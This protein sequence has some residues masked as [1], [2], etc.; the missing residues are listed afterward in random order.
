MPQLKNVLKHVTIETASRRRRC[1]RNEAHAIQ[2]G[3]PCLVVREGE[4]NSGRNYCPEC[5]APM[6]NLA[7]EAIEHLRQGLD[8]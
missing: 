5:A 3:Q 8:L 2:K 4:Y 1:H 6:L 7:E